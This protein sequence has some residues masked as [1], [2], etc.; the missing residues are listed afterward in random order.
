VEEGGLGVRDIQ[1]FNAA[2]VAKW[3][4]R[5][6]SEDGGVW[7]EVIESRYG[8]W[9]DMKNSIADKKK[10][11]WWN[12]LG[13]IC[14][15]HTKSNWFDRKLRWKYGNGSKIRFWEYWWVGEGMLMGKFPRLYAVS[16]KKGL[17]INDF[18][19]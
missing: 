14:E 11:F 8:N 9:R 19:K 5:L 4:W 15:V 3:R 10:S 2:L 13:S 18:G 1:V 7:R 12:D 17:V 16:G 6:G